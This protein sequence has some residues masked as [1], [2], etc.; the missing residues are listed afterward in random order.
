MLGEIQLRN[1]PMLGG[2]KGGALMVKVPGTALFPITCK[3]CNPCRLPR[4]F[5]SDVGTPGKVS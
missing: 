2:G 5:G 1:E 4:S 3:V